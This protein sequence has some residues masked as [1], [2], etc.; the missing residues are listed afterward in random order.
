MVEHSTVQYFYTI[1]GLRDAITSMHS[2]KISKLASKDITK[3]RVGGRYVTVREVER[4]RR[5]ESW[6]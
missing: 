2:S 6:Y 3:C 5:C 1:D 4:S